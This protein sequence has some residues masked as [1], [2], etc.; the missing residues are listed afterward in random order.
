MPGQQA[1]Q[2]RHQA[3]AYIGAGHLDADQGL[4][5]FRAKQGRGGVDDARIHRGAA[6]A[7][8][9]QPRQRHAAPHGQ[10]QQGHAHSDDGLAQADHLPVVELQGQQAADRTADGNAQIE[11][12]GISG[13]RFR[14]HAVVKVQ[15]AAGPQTGGGLQRAVAEEA[16]DHCLDTGETQGLG[17]SQRLA[18]GVGLG[19]RAVLPDRKAQQQHR[20]QHHLDRGDDPVASRPVQAAGE[21][22]AHDV[23][24]YRSADAP[25]AVEPAHVPALKVEGGVI[26]QSR[27]HAARPQ[28]VG[29][30]P[31]AKEQEAVAEGEPKQGHSGGGDGEHGD[32]PGAQPLGQPVRH[33]TRHDRAGADDHGHDPGVRERHSQ[34]WVHGGPGRSQQGVRQPQADKGQVDQG[35]K[36]MGHIANLLLSQT[37]NST[38]LRNFKRFLR[39]SVMW[40]V[41][42]SVAAD[43]QCVP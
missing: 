14:I 15:I 4:G 40:S 3:A 16:Q 26:V 41:H 12:T 2:G 27:V 29:D 1:E 18:G 8:E 6:Q 43:P 21:G 30:G 22:K 10:E 36:K 39:R 42:R 13:G 34:R 25:A 37:Y 35:Q 17:Q 24:A 5:P 19:R 31:K 11:H 33:Q 28:A 32:F 38:D 7:G 20:R 23:R 9:H